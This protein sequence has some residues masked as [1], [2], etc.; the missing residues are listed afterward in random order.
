MAGGCGCQRLAG[1]LTKA[2]RDLQPWLRV[3]RTTTQSL[4]A[5]WKLRKP[6]GAA[7]ALGALISG[8]DYP[9]QLI[10]RMLNCST[11]HARASTF[12]AYLGSQ[13]QSR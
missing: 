12:I 13:R 5:E 1:A 8:I 2:A 6:S 4:R 11:L 7:D 9:R 10:C 3:Y